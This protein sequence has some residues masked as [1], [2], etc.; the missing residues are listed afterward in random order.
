MFTWTGVLDRPSY[1]WRAAVAIVF[2]IGTVFLFPFLLKV[3]ATAS[4][5]QIDTCGAVS[6]VASTALRPLFFVGALAVI[7]SACIRRARDAGL[8]PWMGAFPPLMLVGDQGFLQHAGSGWAYPFSA[9]ILSFHAPIYALFGLILVGLL[10]FPSR[11]VLRYGGN[12]VLDNAI[13]LLA[14]WLSFAAALRASGF[15]PFGL[16]ELPVQITARLFLFLFYAPYTM[17]IFL[18]LAVYRVW[19]SHLIAPATPSAISVSRGEAPNLWQPKRAA[20]IGMIAALAVFFW[21]LSTKG[22]MSGQLLPILLAVYALP[23]LMPTFLLYTGVVVSVLRLTAKRDLI[24]V[25]AL[26]VA[27]IPFGLWAASFSSVQAAK[28]REK[29]AVAAI[30]KVTLPAKVNGV[31]IE[32][33]DWSLINCARIRVLS[34]DREVGDVLT[35][36]QSKSA[37]LRFTRA[38]AGS[39]INQG[40]AA[41]TAPPD[42]V[43]IRLPRQPQFLKDS[44]VGQDIASPAV[45]VYA[46]DPGGTHLVAA[47]YTAINRPPVFPPLLTTHGWYRPENSATTQ[48]SCESVGDFI[49]HEL[50]EKLPA[51][52]A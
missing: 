35:R 25:A 27:L 2:L 16:T 21:S 13:G 45:E 43:L 32:G 26:L 14:G 34:S 19:R 24:A 8:R 12:R 48:E 7:L 52:P 51:D 6:L 46:V 47:T 28:A 37:Y 3:I 30:S 23:I 29:A 38:A 31:V 49:Q 18:A 22:Q 44:R 11:Y 40:Q 20:V 36:G 10:G 50:L 5:C 15:P 39:P 33:D 41:D 17:P 42:Y 9:G 1:A 4:Y